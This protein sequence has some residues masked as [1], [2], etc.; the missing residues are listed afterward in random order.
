MDSKVFCLSTFLFIF[1]DLVGFTKFTLSPY[2]YIYIYIYVCV[3]VCV[4]VC[5]CLCVCLCVCV[6]VI[7]T[8]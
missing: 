7:P 1:L 4:F 5:V 2:I 8:S 3:C 6:R